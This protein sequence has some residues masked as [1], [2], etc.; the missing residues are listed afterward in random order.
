MR[1]DATPP[2]QPTRMRLLQTIRRSPCTVAELASLA[3]ITPNGVRAG[4]AILERDGVVVRAGVRRAPGAG[5]PPHLYAATEY[6]NQMLSQAYVPTL[7]TLVGALA[8]QFPEAAATSIFHA[9]GERLAALIPAPDAA[10]PLA[11][12]AAVLESLGAVVQ[13]AA[14]ALPPT[15][16][17]GSCPL[18]AAVRECPATCELVRTMLARVTGAT[19]VMQCH[20]GESPR[21]SFAVS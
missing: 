2:D 12:T 14:D 1:T 18:A 21:C 16:T 5:K 19:I 13:I 17:G 8:E 11:A 10:T 9:A 3:G 20:H 15:V 7:V 4:L 6:A